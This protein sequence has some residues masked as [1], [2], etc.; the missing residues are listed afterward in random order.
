MICQLYM[1]YDRA[2]SCFI[3]APFIAQ[4]EKVCKRNMYAFV[5][6]S[7][8]PYKEIVDD[9]QLYILGNINVDTGR[10]ESNVSLVS[11][12]NDFKKEV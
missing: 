2:S 8:F 3:G 9:L 5:N 4:N 7:Q 10:I 6:S 11:S 12:L 1:L